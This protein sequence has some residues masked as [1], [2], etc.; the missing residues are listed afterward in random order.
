M[1]RAERSSRRRVLA[2]L[3]SGVAVTLAGCTGGSGDPR[4][5]GRD[6]NADGE[7]RSGN[8]TVAAA[9]LAETEVEE[10][11][12]SLETISIVEHEFVVE[13]G[14]EGSTIQ[15]TVENTGSDRVKVA[16]VRARVYDDADAQIGR[17]VARTGDLDGGGT[18][19][20]TV[21]VLKAP[22]EIARYEVAVLGTPS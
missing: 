6:V 21:V 16:E 9:A 19:A 14:F 10:N 5:E 18:W 11:V 7:G 2:S 1:T 15:G 4:Y 12:T 3:G 20:F 13:D 17:Y 22:A 8:E